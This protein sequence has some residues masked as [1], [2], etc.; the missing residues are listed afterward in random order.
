[1][2][3][4]NERK[5]EL[6]S[7][8]GGSIFENHR[9]TWMKSLGVNVRIKFVVAACLLAM[10]W[11]LSGCSSTSVSPVVHPQNL[12]GRP[13]RGHKLSGRHGTAVA[14]PVTKSIPEF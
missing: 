1:V 7:G 10:L 2:E 8:D 11:F 13:C 4:L 5:N 9:F 14:R 6:Q 3:R 12:P